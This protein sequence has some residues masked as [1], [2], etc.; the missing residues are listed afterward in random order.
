M[1]TITARKT[2]RAGVRTRTLRDFRKPRVRESS[3]LTNCVLCVI[4][5]VLEFA[6][7]EPIG[8]K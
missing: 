1:S 3:N 5:F 7:S 6:N 8:V 4:V 2:S